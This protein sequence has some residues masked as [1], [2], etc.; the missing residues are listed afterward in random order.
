MGPEEPML[1][2]RPCLDVGGMGRYAR[3]LEDAT[4][5]NS[6]PSRTVRPT[7]KPYSAKLG[8]KGKDIWQMGS[9]EPMLPACPYL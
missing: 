2:A 8:K 9:K 1:P 4:L 6:Q 7:A 3:S 5:R